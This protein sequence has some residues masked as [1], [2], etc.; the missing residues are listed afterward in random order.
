MFM[1]IR[2]EKVKYKKVKLLAEDIG[3]EKGAEPNGKHCQ[4]LTTAAD[5][6]KWMPLDLT[7]KCAA[8]LR[9]SQCHHS[10]LPVTEIKS[11]NST[12]SVSVA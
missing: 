1:K 7:S 8:L 12:V 10:S 2:V 11:T 9:E 5:K 4:S 6:E 3:R